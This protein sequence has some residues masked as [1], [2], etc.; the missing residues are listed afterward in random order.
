M[1]AHN[2]AQERE[3]GPAQHACKRQ[4]TMLGGAGYGNATGEGLGITARLRG[5]AAAFVLMMFLTFT[6]VGMLSGALLIAESYDN[7]RAVGV[8]AFN[9]DVQDWNTMSRAAFERLAF[10]VGQQKTKLVANHT[11]EIWEKLQEY[12]SYPHELV[13]PRALF[14]S[15]TLHGIPAAPSIVPGSQQ[16]ETKLELV[17]NVEGGAES[18]VCV[19]LTF[20]E[21]RCR[22]VQRGKMTRQ[23]CQDHLFALQEICIKVDRLGVP[24]TAMDG[25]H[26]ASVDVGCT[27]GTEGMYRPRLTHIWSPGIYKEYNRPVDA[28]LP[29]EIQLEIRSNTDPALTASIYSAGYYDFGESPEAKYRVGVTLLFCC[30]AIMC[31]MCSLCALQYMWPSAPN[32]TERM[33]YFYRRYL[34]RPHTSMNNWWANH[35][36]GTT[37]EVPELSAEEILLEEQATQAGLSDPWGGPQ[38]GG[39]RLGGPMPPLVQSV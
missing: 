8:T 16:K 13:R 28:V 11:A 22:Y 24:T 31:V 7:T 10:T 1:G 4:V 18:K 20:I 2:K 33:K 12:D 17:L 15:T 27:L 34:R 21:T 32:N 35:V 6:V 14:Y 30:G 39:H 3:G 29:S 36:G 23:I 9:A 19:P 26:G 37:A 5:L 38:D 25:V